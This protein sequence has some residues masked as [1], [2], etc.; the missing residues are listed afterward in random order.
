MGKF[1]AINT[2]KAYIEIMQQ[3]KGL[4]ES[5]ELV[6]GEKLPA[7]RVL[8]A[9]LGTSRPTLREALAALEM[10]GYVEIVNGK[11]TFVRLLSE[12]RRAAQV[13]MHFDVEDS[14][15][16]LMEV[17]KAL[18]PSVAALA[19]KRIAAEEL[20]E[21]EVITRRMEEAYAATGRFPTEDDILF[22]EKLVQAARN[23]VFAEVMASVTER[24]KHP[25][26]NVLKGKSH[27]HKERSVAYLAHHRAIVEALRA[28]DG[29]RA[30]R[31]MKEHLASIEED[32]LA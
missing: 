2:Q 7:E 11:G 29:A 6:P 16:Q 5:G 1:K 32:L 22:H 19:A 31:A 30:K 12:D 25:L 14:P 24:M 8:A 21:L 23:V 27:M 9:E 13:D 10:L 3:L 28:G 4:I 20:Q 18:E 15:F 17:R 26:W